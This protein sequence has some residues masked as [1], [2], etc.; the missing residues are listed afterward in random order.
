VQTF[1]TDSMVASSRTFSGYV[2]VDDSRFWIVAAFK[3][4]NGSADGSTDLSGGYFDAQPC[5]VDGVNLGNVHLGFCDFWSRLN[6]D[7]FGQVG[8]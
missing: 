3:G 1:E 8:I 7:G 5:V 4:T 6:D 2:G